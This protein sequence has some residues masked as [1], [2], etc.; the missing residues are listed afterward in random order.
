MADSGSVVSLAIR[1]GKWAA[2]RELMEVAAATGG[3]L[4]G[5]NRSSRNRS[6]TLLS[7]EQ[8]GDAMAELGVDLP[9]YTRRH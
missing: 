7:A 2:M 4:E 9:W 1:T 5:D 6:I 3:G 8:W